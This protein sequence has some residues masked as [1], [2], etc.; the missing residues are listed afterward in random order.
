MKR[1]RVH[2]WKQYNQSLVN[3][4]R[5]DLMISP[6]AVKKWKAFRGQKVI[7]RPLLYSNETVLL[8]MLLKITYSLTYRSLE[9]FALSIL[10]MMKLDL[11]VPDFAHLSRRARQVRLPKKLSNR[12]PRAI[13]L[14]STGLK[15][16]GEG[17]WK[18]KKHGY[19]KRRKWV[20][21]HVAIC[22]TT[23]EFIMGEISDARVTDDQ[24]LPRLIKGSPGSVREVIAD[25]AYDTRKCHQAIRKR[26][27]KP[28]IPPR[29]TARIEP[30]PTK[31]WHERNEAAKLIQYLGGD[32]VAKGIW[33]KATGKATGYHRRSLVETAMYRLKQL[34]GP[35]LYS[36]HRK[37]QASEVFIKLLH[38]NRLTALGM[39]ASSWA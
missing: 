6:E 19:D 21:L 34:T 23:H 9:G 38:L 36:R 20:K 33:K 5:L 1:Y 29:K 17:E 26:G 15:V 8:L 12:R 31:D 27:A 32:P 22:P 14:D 2:N 24:M 11:P 28:V 39:P 25:G 3:R 30:S 7:G 35:N 13:V 37:A 18:V 4:G 16:F 10:A